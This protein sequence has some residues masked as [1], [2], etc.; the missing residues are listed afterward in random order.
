MQGAQERL[1]RLNIQRRHSVAAERVPALVQPPPGG[2]ESA[3]VQAAGQAA[4]RA[5]QS[6]EREAVV[7][8]SCPSAGPVVAAR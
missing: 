1:R 8:A 7:R 6:S 5:V 2:A 4:S 3:E